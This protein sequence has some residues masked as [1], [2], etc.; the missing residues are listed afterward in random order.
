MVIHFVAGM[1]GEQRLLGV[2]GFHVENQSA[3]ML[4]RSICEAG[5]HFNFDYPEKT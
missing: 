4:V 5:I 2:T 1:I 3:S